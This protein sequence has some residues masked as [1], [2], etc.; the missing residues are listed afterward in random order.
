MMVVAVGWVLF[1]AESLAHTAAFLGSMTGMG[2]GTGLVYHTG[3]YLDSQVVLAIIA[4]MVGSAPIL[5][6]VSG[7][8][9]RLVLATRGIGRGVLE[10]GLGFAELVTLS[11][12]LLGSSMLLASG[13]Y[14]PFIYFRF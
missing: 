1:R 5:P 9:K 12:L 6:F 14:N 3:L 11:L 10:S 7:L 4:G 2:K 13:T 8:R